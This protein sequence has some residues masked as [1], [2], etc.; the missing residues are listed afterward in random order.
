MSLL[1]I[2]KNCV[3]VP[4]V[5]REIGPKVVPPSASPTVS[6][7]EKQWSGLRPREL[8]DLIE[9]HTAFQAAKLIEPYKGLWTEAEGELTGEASPEGDGGCS[10]TIS[11]GS[12]GGKLRHVALRFDRSWCD[13]LDGLE[14]KTVVRARGNIVAQGG[15][16][17]VLSGCELISPTLP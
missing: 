11:L 2:K 6:T 10:I 15:V 12:P 4:P 1:S 3:I 14:P 7:E 8:F 5:E 9:G 16:T 13:K 17:L